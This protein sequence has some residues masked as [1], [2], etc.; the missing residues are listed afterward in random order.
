[1][2]P[3][4]I[5]T[6]V[7]ATGFFTLAWLLI[8]IPAASSAVLLLVGRRADRWAPYLGAAAPLASFAIGLVYYARWLA[9]LFRPSAVEGAS[10][11]DVPNGVA[12]AI[13]MTLTAGLV[14]SV[15]PG[16]LLDPVLGVL[17]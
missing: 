10:R 6:P 12:V 15:F 1:M 16:W 7:P 14:F 4:E 13:G 2:L 9:E 5:V 17:G 3:L 8:A 11:Y